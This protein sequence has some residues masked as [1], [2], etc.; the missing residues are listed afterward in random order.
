[1]RCATRCGITY[2][3]F[4]SRICRVF[5][6]TTQRNTELTHAVCVYILFTN[7]PTPEK[8][9]VEKSRT[10]SHEHEN[11]LRAERVAVIINTRYLF[12]TPPK[13]HAALICTIVYLLGMQR[14]RSR[15]RTEWNQQPFRLNV[16]LRLNDCQRE[17]NSNK[18]NTNWCYM[19]V[20]V[21]Q[22]LWNYAIQDYNLMCQIF[23]KFTNFR[24]LFL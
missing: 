15:F 20:Y 6:G 9:N 11:T 2:G 24:E 17:Y 16:V 18:P 3:F 13:M 19:M 21:H 22:H 14:T 12:H 8:K 4:L 7:T 1:M 10:R 23:E 5:N